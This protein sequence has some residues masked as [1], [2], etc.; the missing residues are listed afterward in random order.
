MLDE[1]R[2]CSRLDDRFTFEPTEP[3]LWAC[4]P[5]QRGAYA[6]S[7]TDQNPETP[8]HG[9]PR[10]G[11]IYCYAHSGSTNSLTDRCGA[12]RYAAAAG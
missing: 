12:Y 1:I 2:S 7:D 8:A 5:G 11:S 3:G 4:L 9:Y 6:Y 10:L